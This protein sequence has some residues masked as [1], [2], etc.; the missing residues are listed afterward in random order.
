MSQLDNLESTLMASRKITDFLK[1]FSETQWPRILKATMILGIQEL[2]K[3]H[4]EFGVT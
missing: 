4:C 2:E 3:N 1:L